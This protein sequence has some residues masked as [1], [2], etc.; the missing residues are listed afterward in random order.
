MTTTF[1]NRHLE[2]LYATGRSRKYRLPQPIVFRFVDRVNFLREAES[3]HSLQQ[4][5]SLNFEALHGT[6]LYSIRVDRK[7]RIEFKMEW[8]NEEH[9]IGI[10]GIT[11][12]SNHYGD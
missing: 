3:I 1:L 4:R 8:T 11:E 2:E 12:L 10:V 9:T 7:Y 5:P 6:D